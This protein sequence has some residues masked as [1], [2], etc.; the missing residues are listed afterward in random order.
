MIMLDGCYHHGYK[1]VLVKDGCMEQEFGGAGLS[2]GCAG[3]GRVSGVERV[4]PPIYEKYIPFPQ[5]R[6]FCSRQP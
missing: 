5:S 2:W 3:L 1:D 6:L 4:N